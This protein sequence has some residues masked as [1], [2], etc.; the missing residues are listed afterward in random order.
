MKNDVIIIGAGI[1][2]MN[3]AMQLAAKGYSV[4]VLEKRAEPGGKMR[5]IHY[6]DCTFDAGPSLITMPF[7]LREAFAQTG[8]KLEDYIELLSIDPI[9]HYRWLDG[10]SYE[11]YADPF[12]RNDHTEKVFGRKSMQEM[13]AYLANAGKVYHATK[14]VFLFNPFD[15]FKEFFKS[16]NLPLLPALPSLKFSSKFHAFNASYFSNPKLIQLFDRFATYNGSSPFLAPATLMVIPFI[17]FEYGGWYPKG[18][19]YAI[20]EAFHKRCI[21]LGVRFEFN[22]DV[23]EIITQK[24]IATGV[25]TKDGAIHE[26]SHIISNTD[27]YHANHDLLKK[28]SEKIPQLSTSGFVMLLPMKKNP[29]AMGHHTVMFSDAYEQEFTSIF[30]KHAA[31]DEMTVYISVSSKTDSTQASENLE[32]W[33]VLVNTPPTSKPQEWNNE[34][35]QRY[36]STV[37]TMME[38]FLPNMQSYISEQPFIITPD[39]FASEFHATGGSL[40]GSSSNSMFSAFLRPQNKDPKFRNLYHCGG[41]AHPGGGIPLVVLSGNFAAQAVIEDSHKSRL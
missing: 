35:K 9:C 7:I 15:G 18:G 30:K 40:Y 38:R 26:A 39:D 14:D 27:V 12:K 6:G 13:N 20:A 37:L 11:C 24:N 25:K 19:I 8:A 32:N 22:A 36:A 28:K 31:P 21:E 33:F 23:E 34:E 3:A 17:E 5:R 2:G 10:T 1:G 16:K 4:T 29:F 41:S